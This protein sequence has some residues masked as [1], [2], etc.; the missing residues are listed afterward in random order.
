MRS[1]SVR[2]SCRASEVDTQLMCNE[3]R[4]YKAAKRAGAMHEFASE[5]LRS[6]S[7]P[8]PFHSPQG[9]YVAV[10]ILDAHWDPQAK[11]LLGHAALGAGGPVSP[12]CKIGV[13]G[14]HSCWAWPRSL[15]EVVPAFMDSSDV[16]ERHVVNDLGEC[17]TVWETINVG[18][19]AFIHEVGHALN[20][21]HHRTGIMA[22]GYNEW[23]RAFVTAEG[24]SKR[25]NTSGCR[26]I[27]PGMDDKE[28][29]W[30]RMSLLQLRYHPTMRLP[31]DP[32]IPYQ[33]TRVAPF[34]S[35]VKDGVSISAPV[36]LGSIELSVNDR[37]VKHI[38]FPFFDSN[39]ALPPQ[40]YH[41]TT[42]EIKRLC[43]TDIASC[44]LTVTACGTDQ[45]K[46][47]IQDYSRLLKGSR[48]VITT[49]AEGPAA[50]VPTSSRSSSTSKLKRFAQKHLHQGDSASASATTV[51]RSDGRDLRPGQFEAIKGIPVGS[52]KPQNPSFLTIFNSHQSSRPKLVKVEVSIRCRPLLPPGPS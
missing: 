29:H 33:Y 28:N 10:L 30:D 34:I 51:A 21:P 7:A 8:A 4:Q 36:G 14:S 20:L 50:P 46:A 1:R 3:G 6:P 24:R 32:L 48:L 47:E 37:F 25:C 42:E 11:L 52:E 38:E 17:G 43:Q 19:G 39:S 22:R 26:Q 40:T 12:G 2:P 27:A 18:H 23:N 49:T 41:L 31:R 16:D 45:R 13:F 9:A 35:V 44:K 5:A 15:I